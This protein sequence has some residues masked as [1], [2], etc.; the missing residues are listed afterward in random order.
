M[1][2]APVKTDTVSKPATPRAKTPSVA[3]RAA[4]AAAASRITSEP[5]IVEP[6]APASPAETLVVPEPTQ[7][8]LAASPTQPEAAAPTEAKGLN[9]MNDTVKQVQETAQKMAADAT[10]HVETFVAGATEKAKE[11]G[12]KAKK[13]A[14][15]AVSFQKDNAEAVVASGKLLAEGV[16]SSAAYAA[17]L[18]RKH[19]EEA[20]ATLK[21]LAAAKS[22][23]EFFTLQGDYMKSNYEAFIAESSKSSEATMKFFGEVFQPISSRF[24][25]AAEKVKA[26]ATL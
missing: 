20:S 23:S 5:K 13:M 21:T 6:A 22:P 25:L 4:E 9:I 16:Q 10:A 19:F 18:G 26:A 15:D 14:E 12:E 8:K 3:K 17:E 1:A 11:A 24:A 2:K 7:P